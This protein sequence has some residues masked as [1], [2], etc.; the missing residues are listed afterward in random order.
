MDIN[1]FKSK[2]DE[3]QPKTYEELDDIIKI[4]DVTSQSKRGNDI[5][6]SGRIRTETDPQITA[7]EQPHSIKRFSVMDDNR[8]ISKKK[9]T[10]DDFE[11]IT[12]SGRGAYGTVLQVYLKKRSKQEGICYKKTRYTFFIFSK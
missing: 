1:N 2:K 6:N 7:K 4:N 8:L 9:F 11:V 5:S 12:L 10:K 3:I